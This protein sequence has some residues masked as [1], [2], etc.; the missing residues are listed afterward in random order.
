MSDKIKAALD[1]IIE[2]FESGDVPEAIAYTTFPVANLPSSK[3]SFLNRF[4][5]VCAGTMDARGFRQWELVKRQVKGG[6]KAFYIITPLMVKKETQQTDD[7]EVIRGFKASPVFRVED[8]GGAPLEYENIKLPN[9]PL[10]DKAKEW[11][12]NVKAIPG[13]YSYYGYFSNQRNEIAM[14]TEEESVFFHELAHASHARIR[15][16]DGNQQSKTWE[17]EIVAELSAATL[18]RI[19]GKTSKHLG[20]SYRYIRHYSKK[21]GLTPIKGILSVL[22]TV[23]QVLSQIL[24]SQSPKPLLEYPLVVCET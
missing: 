9:I 18:C 19:V 13:N 11:G 10:M 2:R 5:M 14:A 23:E 6:R 8:T 15:N 1:G 7:E 20:N 3:W 21:A 17:K 22:A 4:L 12:I 24:Q 16:R